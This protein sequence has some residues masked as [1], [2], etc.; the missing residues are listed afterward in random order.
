M[1]D[2]GGTWDGILGTGSSIGVVVI[3]QGPSP[4]GLWSLPS[5]HAYLSRSPAETDRTTWPIGSTTPSDQFVG[6]T[7]P[8]AA[9]TYTTYGSN[10]IEIQSINT[11]ALC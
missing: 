11:L 4:S 3:V 8:T 10:Y 7:S 1:V 9:W 6:F 5:A 2:H